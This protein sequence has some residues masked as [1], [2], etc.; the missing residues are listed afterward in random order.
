MT[1]HSNINVTIRSVRLEDA[2]A[3]LNLNREIISEGEFFI[4]VEQ[5]YEKTLEQQIQS[6]QNVIQN[7]RETMLIA[8]IDGVLVGTIVFSSRNLKRLSHTGTI[9]ISIKKEY[10][11]MGIGN[12]LLKELL[13]WAEQ[14][15]FIEKVS[16][17]V[18]ATNHRAIALYKKLGFVEEG[19][20]IKEVKLY[21]NEYIDDILMYKLV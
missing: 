19:R 17:G 13:A 6:I 5:E 10:R 1:L 16:L 4:V 3:I 12:L 11:N 8:A 20:K 21:D 14:N 15:P 9:S 7:E 18:L 2:E